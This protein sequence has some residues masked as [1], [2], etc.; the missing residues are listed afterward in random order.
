[1][2][3]FTAARIDELTKSAADTLYNLGDG[4]GQDND[5][6]WEEA[7]KY[8]RAIFQMLN[9]GGISLVSSVDVKPNLWSK[10]DR[11]NAREEGNRRWKVRMQRDRVL[12][13]DHDLYNAGAINGFVLGAE[14]WNSH[15]GES[16]SNDANNSFDAKLRAAT[17]MPSR[18]G[19]RGS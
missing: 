6:T 12:D 15:A 7:E 16:N 8:A 14:W 3:R 17:G 5:L 11:R 2:N 13:R 10:G 4:N 1:M 9:A 18:G 19:G